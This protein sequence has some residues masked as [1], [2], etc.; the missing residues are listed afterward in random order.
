MHGYYV[1]AK[2]FWPKS[3]QL[4]QIPLYNIILCVHKYTIGGLVYKY[5]FL[6]TEIYQPFKRVFFLGE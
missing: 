6:T 2:K 5:K 1:P 3:V 4:R